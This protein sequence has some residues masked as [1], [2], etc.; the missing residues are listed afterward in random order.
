MDLKEN[1]HCQAICDKSGEKQDSVEEREEDLGDVVIPGAQTAIARGRGEVVHGRAPS[2][3]P[4][5][6]G[7][8]YFQCQQLILLLFL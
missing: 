3:M 7:G 6:E 5:G 4:G 8:G 1:P 2:S